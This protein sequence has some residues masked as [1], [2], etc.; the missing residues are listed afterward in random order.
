MAVSFHSSTFGASLKWLF[1]ELQVLASFFRPGGCCLAK[2]FSSS[3][4]S[5]LS[6]LNFV[7]I[8]FFPEVFFFF[9]LL[10]DPSDFSQSNSNYFCWT[11]LIARL[12][13]ILVKCEG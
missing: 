6:S 12:V 8:L 2:S 11:D 5:T 3:F 4:I 1:E 13:S 10:K 9:T 7:I